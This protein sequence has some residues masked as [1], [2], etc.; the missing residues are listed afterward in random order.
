MADRLAINCLRSADAACD[1]P[2][3]GFLDGVLNCPQRL[4]FLN[5]KFHLMQ[6][7]SV[8]LH[9]QADAKFWRLL[10]RIKFT[11]HAASLTVCYSSSVWSTVAALLHVPHHDSYR[12]FHFQR[13]ASFTFHIGFL[14]S[15]LWTR[16]SLDVIWHQDDLL[17]SLNWKLFVAQRERGV[18]YK[19]PLLT[20]W[21]RTHRFLS[22]AYPSITVDPSVSL[23]LAANYIRCQYSNLAHIST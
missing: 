3:I 10:F 19:T 6:F 14:R 21:S 18:L 9:A 23:C 7:S 15:L 2:A 16:S 11:Q 4:A 17:I 20:I 5:L 13:V 1:L 12:A 8:N 22:M